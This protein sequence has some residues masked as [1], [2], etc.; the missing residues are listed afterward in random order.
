MI[1][2]PP[3]VPVA[4]QNA[5]GQQPTSVQ[6]N[7]CLRRCASRRL[8]EAFQAARGSQPLSLPEEFCLFWKELLFCLLIKAV[9]G[10]PL[11]RIVLLVML[12]LVL[13]IRAVLKQPPPLFLLRNAAKDHPQGPPT[14]NRQPPTTANRQP[15]PTT[16]RQPP[17]ERSAGQGA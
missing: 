15:S 7:G 8:S 9:H 11:Q 6:S 12:F 16:N 3:K 5:I 4:K 14:A 2:P 10:P 13:V 1:P 17:I